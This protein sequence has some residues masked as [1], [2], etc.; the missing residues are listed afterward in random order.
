MAAP[1]QT[2]IEWLESLTGPASKEPDAP[3][4]P[5]FPRLMVR[6]FAYY[7]Q[8]IFP[9]LVQW[10]ELTRGNLGLLQFAI[11]VF[12]DGGPFDGVVNESNFSCL[13]EVSGLPKLR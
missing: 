8:H 9:L 1:S 2:V 10:S 7:A 3:S 13:D 5:L 12:E 11:D 4:A 6:D